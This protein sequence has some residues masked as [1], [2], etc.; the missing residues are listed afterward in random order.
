MI[1]YLADVEEVLKDRTVKLHHHEVLG[2]VGVEELLTLHLAGLD[3]HHAL[4]LNLVKAR[5]LGR[6]LYGIG[7]C[8]NDKEVSLILVRKE[9]FNR[10]PIK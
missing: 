2:S 1:A 6:E 7:T 10:I 9:L 3:D 4:L 5:S 8:L